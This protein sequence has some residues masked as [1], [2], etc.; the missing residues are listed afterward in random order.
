MNR[1]ERVLILLIEDETKTAQFL[2]QGLEEK[3]YAVEVAYDGNSGKD[4]A[5]LN[6]HD[7]V[8]T[9]VILPG[10]DG[11]MV[12]REIRDMGKDI[13]I[14]M[15]T[16]L[17][18]TEDVVAGLESGADDYLAKPFAFDELLARVRTLIR[19]HRRTYDPILTAADLTLDLDQKKVTRAGKVINLTPK[20][21]GLLTYFMLNR[22]RVVSKSEL[23]SKVWKI[24]FETGTNMVEVYV[25]YLRKKIDQDFSPKLIVTHFGSGYELRDPD[26]H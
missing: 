15:L 23:A 17:G 7:L 1:S 8:I 18:A 19:R 16:A 3:G 12:C 6:R 25:N 13:P 26:H 24:N 20:E 9:D 4:L 22:N 21:F 5:R 14:L 2:K 10:I 11:K